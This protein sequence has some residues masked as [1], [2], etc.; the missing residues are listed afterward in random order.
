MLTVSRLDY[1]DFRVQGQK[2]VRTSSKKV[3]LQT[4]N[5]SK[6]NL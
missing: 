2:Y 5:F 1:N 3:L 4:A 6:E